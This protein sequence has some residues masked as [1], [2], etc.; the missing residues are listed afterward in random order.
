MW[1]LFLLVMSSSGTVIAYD[2]GR[3]DSYQ[4]CQYTGEAM[5]SELEDAQKFIC[6]EW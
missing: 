1:I 2:Q 4:S 6:V 3:F 5:I